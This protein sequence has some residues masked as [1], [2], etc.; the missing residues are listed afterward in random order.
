MIRSL[1]E[2][3]DDE[4]TAEEYMIQA[5]E[6]LKQSALEDGET[7]P[8]ELVNALEVCDRYDILETIKD[9]PVYGEEATL[10]LKY[11]KQRDIDEAAWKAH[12]EKYPPILKEMGEVL[13]N[14]QKIGIFGVSYPSTHAKRNGLGDNFFA[15]SGDGMFLFMFEVLSMEDRGSFRLTSPPKDKRLNSDKECPDSVVF[16][17]IG[18]YEF[19]A[20][21]T[22]DQIIQTLKMIHVDDLC[23]KH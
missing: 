5:E 4:I 7:D 8:S 19:G 18:N 12:V 6:F 14:S 11:K 9:H 22:G 20:I 17:K 1:Y 21:L 3:A 16:R 10:Q 13:K 23:D 2:L 15:I